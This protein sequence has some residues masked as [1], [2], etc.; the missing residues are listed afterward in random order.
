MEQN[1]NLSFPISFSVLL[2]LTHC[3]R[4][5]LPNTAKDPSKKNRVKIYRNQIRWI[6]TH[7]FLRCAIKPQWIRNIA[8]WIGCR[9]VRELNGQ[10]AT[11]SHYSFAFVHCRTIGENTKKIKNLSAWNSGW[12]IR[13]LQDERLRNYPI[14]G[15][16]PVSTTRLMALNKNS[17]MIT[18][19]PKLEYVYT[20]QIKWVFMIFDKLALLWFLFL[21]PSMR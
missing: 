21:C 3:R 12:V 19:G 14:G 17:V 2:L 13:R 15:L 1:T 4:I 6:E 20:D 11:R 18:D 8:R 16:F 5:I 7:L 10:S 9:I